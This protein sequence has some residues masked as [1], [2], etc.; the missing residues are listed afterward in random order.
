[1]RKPFICLALVVA[2]NFSVSA[3]LSGPLSGTL[4]PGNYTVI[5]DISVQPEDSLTIAPG[6][7]LWF[8]NDCQ[9]TISGHL[10]AVGTQQDPICFGSYYS[11]EN[12]RGID[13]DNTT[14]DSCILKYCRISKSSSSGISCLRSSPII[15]DCYISSNYC[16]GTS[17]IGGGGISC[18]ESNAIIERC[19]IRNN[20]DCG[21]H[22]MT[23]GGGIFC[24]YSY[25]TVKQCTISCNS[26]FSGGGVGIAGDGR[27]IIEECLIIENCA[28]GIGGGI[29]IF[30]YDYPGSKILKSIIKGNHANRGGGIYCTGEYG[31]GEN[32]IGVV[33]CVIAENYALSGSGICMD[34]VNC[35]VVKNTVFFSNTGNACIEFLEVSTSYISYCNFFNNLN[36]NFIG[37]S[38]PNGLGQVSII[39][40]NGDSCDAYF[41]IYL[42]PAFHSTTGDSAYHLTPGSPCID[43]GD[44]S[45]AYFEPEDPWNPG[46]ALYPAMGTRFSDIGAFGGPGSAVWV[47][48]APRIP[49]EPPRDCTLL[50]NYPNPFNSETALSFKLQAASNVKLMI[51]DIMGREMALLAEGFY[52]TGTHQVEWD[53]SEVASGVYFARLEV[54]GEAITTKLL[55]MK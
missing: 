43:A 24:D 54:R 31:L 4:G 45:R 29:C 41:N 33:N 48:V 11:Y 47:E 35:G 12:W 2:I 17:R 46:H 22:E 13:F 53:A 16:F 26:S 5:G 10:S 30:P 38:I 19:L 39:N 44:P 51:Y 15:S 40:A 52:P 32:E 21:F 36:V 28:S 55:L 34:L 8:Y 6:T 23:G 1:M 14:S 27:A 7:I 37:D 50:R 3:Q 20:F 9:F 49:F 18:F 25:I 42:D